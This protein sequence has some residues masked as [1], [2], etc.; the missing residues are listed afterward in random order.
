VDFVGSFNGP[1][2]A[3]GIVRACGCEILR[4]EFESSRTIR[5]GWLVTLE[6]EQHSAWLEFRHADLDSWLAHCCRRSLP[7]GCGDAISETSPQPP[8]VSHRFVWNQLLH[9]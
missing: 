5:S 2:L 6:V 8:D 7:P 1:D 9:P 3:D 4:G